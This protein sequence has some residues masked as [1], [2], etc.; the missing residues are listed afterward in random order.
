MSLDNYAA[1]K[2]EI[3]DWLDRDDIDTQI[4]TFIDL[5]E[6]RH[7][8]EIRIREMLARQQASID[9]QY[10]VLPTGFLQMR[11]LR[12]LTTPVTRLTEVSPHEMTRL[13]S[14]RW[15]TQ[16]GRPCAFTVHEEIEFDATP[17]QTYTAEMLFWQELTPLSDSNTTNALLIRAPDAYLFG[18]LVAS[19][20]F[21]E[22]EER[23]P[24]WEA[25]YSLARDDINKMDRSL[26]GPL[27]SR[28][29]GAT[30]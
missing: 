7:Q 30:P 25:A 24:T 21:L 6:S 2:S 5:A 26:S 14:K 17:D 29:A 1:L 27:V 23:L 20:P 11:E 13:R 16:T 4:D 15:I 12:L 28:V 8:R 10:E 3:G 9:A 18:A 22:H 19:G